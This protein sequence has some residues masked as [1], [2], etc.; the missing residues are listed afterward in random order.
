[1]NTTQISR[2]NENKEWAA[3]PSLLYFCALMLLVGAFTSS[4]EFI[5]LMRWVVFTIFTWSAYIAWHSKRMTP[6]AVH[7][8]LALV[9]NPIINLGLTRDFWVALDIFATVLVCT[10][11][12]LSRRKHPS[13]SDKANTRELLGFIAGMVGMLLGAVAGVYLYKYLGLGDFVGGL[14]AA[15]MSSAGLYSAILIAVKLQK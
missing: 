8:S 5:K 12:W 7:L 2:K 14:I 4:Y 9:F 3:P 10:I 11:A 15:G 13:D 1:M 6:V